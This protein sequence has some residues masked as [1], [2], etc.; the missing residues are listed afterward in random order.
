MTLNVHAQSYPCDVS[1]QCQGEMICRMVYKP[2]LSTYCPPQLRCVPPPPSGSSS[3]SLGLPI[4]AND[5]KTELVCGPRG[6]KCPDETYCKSDP[7]DG[8]AA[9][10]WTVH[11]PGS[12][13]IPLSRGSCTVTCS[14]DNNCNGDQ[15]C[16]STGCGFKCMNPGP[17]SKR[18]FCPVSDRPSTCGT[19]CKNDYM[20]TGSQKCCVTKCGTQCEKPITFAERAKQWQQKTM[21]RSLTTSSTVSRRTGAVPQRKIPIF[22]QPPARGIGPVGQKQTHIFGPLPTRHISPVGQKQTQGF[23]PPP[24]RFTNPVGQKQKQGFAP[25]P[26]RLTNPVGQKPARWFPQQS[27]RH[28]SPVGQNQA[29]GFPQRTD[30]MVQRSPQTSNQF[31]KSQQRIFTLIPNPTS[32]KGKKPPVN[33]QPDTPWLSLTRAYMEFIMSQPNRFANLSSQL[34]QRLAAYQN[35]QQNPAKSR[36]AVKQSTTVLPISANPQPQQQSIGNTNNPSLYYPQP[37]NS[38]PANPPNS[39]PA[40]PPNSFPAKPPSNNFERVP[41]QFVSPTVSNQQSANM[42]QPSVG[43]TSAT[44]SKPAP[45]HRF[46]NQRMPDPRSSMGRPPVQSLGSAASRGNTAAVAAAAAAAAA[47]TTTTTAQSKFTQ[48]DPR[49][50]TPG[51]CPRLSALGECQDSCEVDLSC[52]AKQKCCNVGPC[53]VCLVPTIARRGCPWQIKMFEMC[54]LLV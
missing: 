7:V 4:L 41:E 16:C 39:F 29:R 53:K 17:E 37:P 48:M 27:T 52:P 11:K 50:V 33:K 36:P 45:P 54:H 47:A 35:V 5:N 2:C 44:A 26:T 15:K 19:P 38:F 9:C 42:F 1:D 34:K 22:L 25:P 49:G 8:F 3:C 24:T 21:L 20:C 31:S 12:C 6:S 23:A 10:C 43:S 40:K 30:P 32:I 14:N 13:P 51:E 46:P 28:T 18:G